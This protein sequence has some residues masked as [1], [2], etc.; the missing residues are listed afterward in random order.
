MYLGCT[1]R[2]D[3]MCAVSYFGRFLDKPN[4]ELCA[5]EKRTLRYLKNTIDTG[6]FYKQGEGSLEA[7][8]GADWAGDN[9][10]RKS[11]NG[12]IQGVQEDL[13]EQHQKRVPPKEKNPML[14]IRV[15]EKKVTLFNLGAV[16]AVVVV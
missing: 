10:D 1:S 7:F 11:S 5:V 14:Q 4:Q 3:M 9:S 15:C 6:L 2:P 16:D 8:S 12:S 13:K